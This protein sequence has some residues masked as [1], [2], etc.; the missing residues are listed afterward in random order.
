VTK[1]RRSQITF[2]VSI[3]ATVSPYEVKELAINTQL[4]LADALTKLQ[5]TLNGS[6]VPP[7]KH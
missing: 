3:L 1:K 5:T 4:L 2:A 6:S 7:H